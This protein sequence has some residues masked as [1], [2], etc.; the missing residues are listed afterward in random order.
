[1]LLPNAEIGELAGGGYR[2]SPVRR[3]RRGR[4]MQ[5][6]ADVRVASTSLGC[7]SQAFFRKGSNPYQKLRVQQ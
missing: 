1:M 3:W 4:G 7:P 2:P 5:D 6:A